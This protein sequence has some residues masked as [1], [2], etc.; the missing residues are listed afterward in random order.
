MNLKVHQEVEQEFTIEELDK[1][2]SEA[3]N[4]M[5]TGEDDI[6]YEMLKNLGV[7]A[8]EVLLWL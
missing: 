2:L 6:P 1:A 4:N 7:K 5:A 3:K 8:K